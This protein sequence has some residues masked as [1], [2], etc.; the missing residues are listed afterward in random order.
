MGHG[1]G[2]GRT[3]VKKIRITTPCFMSHEWCISEA[4]IPH[5]GEK[6]RKTRGF[7]LWQL[8][9]RL[10]RAFKDAFFLGFSKEVKSQ[11]SLCLT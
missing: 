6:F 9:L 1:G 5:L 8:V 11:V 10:L 4:L 3:D 7:F 2:L